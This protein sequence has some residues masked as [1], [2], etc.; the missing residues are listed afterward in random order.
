MDQAAAVASPRRRRWVVIFTV[1]LA[2]TLL[3]A[4]KPITLDDGAY[5]QM[6]WWIAAYPADPYGFELMWFDE[7]M[8]GHLCYTPPVYLYWWAL[9]IRLFGV[10]PF[11]WK[12][13][14]FPFSLL[15]T[16]GLYG[17]FRYF[18]RGLE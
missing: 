9:A 8:Q 10:Q 14:L 5:Y 12:L 15:L 6:A 17:L 4:V 3:N 7:P 11:L 18:A 2:F 1:A 16:Y 13:W